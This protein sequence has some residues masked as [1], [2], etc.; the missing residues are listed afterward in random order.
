MLPDDARHGTEAGA[1]A[2]R[3]AGQKA[4]DACSRARCRADQLRLIYPAK[5]SS[6]GS[7]R[8]I[9][10]LQAIGW[11]RDRIA[12]EMGYKD[13]GAFSYLMSTDTIRIVTAERIREVYERLSMT[14][15]QG[16]GASRAR[17][18]ARRHGYAPPLAYDD[19][20]DPS[21]TPKGVAA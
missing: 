2:H 4:C 6:L 13:G 12:V 5:T 19:I 15:P 17:T 9:H 20:D 16:Q 11:S 10:A 1:T 18:W 8:R 14:V 3:R 7:Q 21:E